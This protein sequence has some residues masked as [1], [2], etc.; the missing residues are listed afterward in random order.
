MESLT[1]SK[2]LAEKPQDRDTWPL[3]PV[4]RIAAA[5]TTKFTP[6]ILVGDPGRDL[7]RLSLA[8]SGDY[9]KYYAQGIDLEGGLF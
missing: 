1:E 8:R 2:Y 7:R 4:R 5:I 3:M 6:V 9:D